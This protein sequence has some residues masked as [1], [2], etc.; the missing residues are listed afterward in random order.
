[1]GLSSCCLAPPPAQGGS[2]PPAPCLCS[3]G[4]G[5]ICQLRHTPLKACPD[6][7]PPH[8]APCVDHTAPDPLSLQQAMSPGVGGSC[9]HS[10]AVRSPGVEEVRAMRKR[11]LL[12]TP[13]HCPPGCWEL[14]AVR[15]GD[16]GFSS[17]S[18]RGTVGRAWILE[19]A[20]FRAHHGPM[21]WCRTNPR[22]G[23]CPTP[24]A[25]MTRGQELPPS[26]PRGALFH[27]AGLSETGQVWQPVQDR[28]PSPGAAREPGGRMVS[29][30]QAGSWARLTVG[31]SRAP[32]EVRPPGPTCF[33][34]QI[35]DAEAS[36]MSSN[37][38]VPSKE[39]D[40]GRKAS[41]MVHSTY[42]G[43]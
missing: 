9:S 43:D 1:M 14:Q 39:G 19:V 40:R 28:G 36:F 17:A 34:S 31:G 2:R 41:T 33:C 35:T 26:V 3:G 21:P 37:A 8:Q 5:S 12:P 16:P 29:A 30:G 7:P 38:G 22:G 4:P 10:R 25:R 24:G 13:G 6:H 27:P 20:L 18:C 42:R 11:V 23:R 15:K 32:L